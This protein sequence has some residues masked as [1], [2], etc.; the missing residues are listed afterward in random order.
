MELSRTLDLWSG[1]QKVVGNVEM[2]IS[3]TECKLTLNH[4]NHAAPVIGRFGLDG[5]RAQAELWREPLEMALDILDRGLEFRVVDWSCMA[6][7]GTR[8]FELGVSLRTFGKDADWRQVRIGTSMGDVGV[9]SIE[10]LAKTD[11]LRSFA[12][13]CLALLPVPK[14][15]PE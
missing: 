14:E 2:A 6:M 13:G 1:H 9:F 10:G 11:E 15:T 4:K 7:R 8:D 12:E 3:P 5:I